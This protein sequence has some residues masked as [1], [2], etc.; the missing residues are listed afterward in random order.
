MVWLQLTL[1]STRE[2][3]E[4][5]SELLEKYGAI[6]VS[7]SAL[8]DEP[9]FGQ[10]M[11]GEVLLWDRTRVSALLHEDIDLDTL[12]VCLNKRVGAGNILKHHID[13]LQDQEWVNTYQQ[14]QGPKIFGERLFIFPSWCT[15]PDD[16]KYHII[17]DPGLAFGT[18]S[19]D[20]TAMCLDW[21]AGHDI[22]CKRVI[23][24]GCGSGILAL[25]ALRL[26]AQHAF[27]TDIDP[28]ALQATRVNAERNHLLARITIA[29]PDEVTL[30]AVNVLLANVLLSP[31]KEL[32]PI[33]SGLVL[34]GGDIV[35]SG[36]LGTQ[37][38][39]CLAA[40]QSWFN[41]EKPVYRREWTLLHG[42]KK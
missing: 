37:A 12:L 13:L 29:H 14:G 34:P 35:L 40:Y 36:L 26:G 30:P 20:T 31:L 38:E 42:V 11:V 22:N 5:L 10:G 6:S 2:N 23:D 21:L 17:L 7:L 32:A 24:Y 39:E 3:A 15:P 19:H 28:Q 18:G 9:M 33:F 1:E 16:T 41:M 25:A 8:S 27:A 4:Q